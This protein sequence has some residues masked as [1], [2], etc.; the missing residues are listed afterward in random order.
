MHLVVPEGP[1]L[2]PEFD[3]CRTD[4]SGVQFLDNESIYSMNVQSLCNKLHEFDNFVRETKPA[5]VCVCE[6]FFAPCLQDSAVCPGGYKVFRKDRV[7]KGGGVAIFTRDDLFCVSVEVKSNVQD[8]DIVCVDVSLGS[9]NLRVIA[10]YRPPYYSVDDIRYLENMLEI[11]S[12]LCSTISKFIIVGDFNLPH[13]DWDHY[14]A[15]HEKCHDMFITF[16]NK[17]GL[18]QLITESTRSHNILDLVSGVT[19]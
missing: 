15:S 17:L 7:Q 14:L 18:D 4:C 9:E 12:D 16:V 5:V 1:C 2:L 8:V 19:T 3:D 13:I 11:V 6:T 10:C